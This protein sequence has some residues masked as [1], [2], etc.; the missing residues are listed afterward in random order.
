MD[1]GKIKGKDKGRIDGERRG[2]GRE[3]GVWRAPPPLPQL[4]L[5]DPPVFCYSFRSVV[6]LI[7]AK[8]FFFIFC[9]L[10]GKQTLLSFATFR[11]QLKT[12]LFS[13]RSA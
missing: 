4:Q 8:L 9:Q 10:H 11:R 3:E 5:V 6:K 1:K 2:E 7:V 12:F 13:D